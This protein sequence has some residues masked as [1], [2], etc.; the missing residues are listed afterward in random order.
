MAGEAWNCPHCGEQILRSAV[1]CPACRRHIRPDAVLSRPVRAAVCPLGVDGT[2]RH[3]GSGDPWEYS[4]LVE[5]RDDRGEVVSRRVVGIGALY[6][7]QSRRVT[8]R[9]EILAPEP[10]SAGGHVATARR[11]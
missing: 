8:L 11:S 6:P 2:I 5:I 3:P 9:V 7:G 4:A 1:S 10:A